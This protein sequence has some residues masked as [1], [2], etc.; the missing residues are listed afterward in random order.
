MPPTHEP[1]AASTDHDLSGGAAA[2]REAEWSGAT[3]PTAR[4]EPPDGLVVG[5][6]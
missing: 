5:T 6:R 2:R 3:R 4:G 1:W